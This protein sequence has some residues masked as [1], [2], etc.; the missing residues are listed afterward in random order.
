MHTIEIHIRDLN[1]LFNSMDPAP[2]RHKDLDLKAEEFIVSLAQEL[3]V[4]NDINL[5]IHLDQPP[6]SIDADKAAIESIHNY[7]S[8]RTSMIDREFR[9]LMRRGRI[10]LIIGLGFLAI[11]LSVANLIGSIVNT[12][13]P[14]ALLKDSF[15]IGGWVA[16]WCPMEI[17]L[18]D[19]WPL[20]AR[21]KLMERLSAIPIKFELLVC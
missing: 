6:I 17:F 2:F 21:E 20:K 9:Q 12:Y 5:T 13:T 4:E 16:M 11:C 8:Y 19:W 18:Y 3:P 1:Q 7:F 15:T 14:I 10:S